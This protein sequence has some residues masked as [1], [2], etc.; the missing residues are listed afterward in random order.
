MA[1]VLL[2]ILK[3]IG[4]VLLSIIAL[5]LLLLIIF[6]FVP[7]RY[8][9]KGSFKDKIPKAR[10]SV[11]YLLYILYASFQYE[12]GFSYCI[13]IFGIKLD[14]KKLKKKKDNTAEDNKTEEANKED[15][16]SKE[17]EKDS[18]PE[19]KKSISE[20]INET[21]QKID[22]AIDILSRDTTKEALEVTKY[23]IGKAIRSIL[24]YK[25]KIYA[26]IGLEN[27]G[28][29]GKILGVY[30]ALYDYIGDVVTFYPVF[31]SEVIDVSFD[32]KGRIRAATILY[33][34]VRIYMD[35][36]C[37]RLIKMLIKSKRRKDKK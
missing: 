4:I 25:G 23:R 9:A 3:I 21:V 35:K 15:T 20:K 33:H 18:E 29:T 11:S 36:N 5:L 28:T 2:T 24:P 17:D 10:F 8:K 16:A 31:D 27:A 7:V 34:L 26:R 32:L 19:E 6:L 12:C 13:R 37:R 30:K 14:L 1:G 22:K